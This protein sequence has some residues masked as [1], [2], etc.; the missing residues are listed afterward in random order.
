MTGPEAERLISMYLFNRTV[1]RPEQVAQLSQWLTADQTH[2]DQYLDSVRFHLLLRHYFRSND[3][4]RQAVFAEDSAI[5]DPSELEQELLQLLWMERRSPPIPLERPTSQPQPQEPS[6]CHRVQKPSRFWPSVLVAATAAVVLLAVCI[7]L[8]PARPVA[9]ATL[10][11]TM[12]VQ[13]LGQGAGVVRGYRFMNNGQPFRLAS[14]LVRLTFDNNAEFVVQGPTE[15]RICSA[16]R[17]NLS[18]GTLWATVPPLAKGFRVDLPGYGIV[19]LGTEFGLQADVDGTS[20]LLMHKGKVALIWQAEGLQKGQEIIS[21]GLACQIGTGGQIAPTQIEPNRFVRAFNSQT[22][23]VWRGEPLDL[24]DVVGGGNGL[25]RGQAHMGI[26]IYTGLTVPVTFGPARQGPVGYVPAVGNSLIDGVF[27]PGA[28]GSDVQVSSVGHIWRGC[29][30]TSGALVMGPANGGYVGL[31]QDRL[32]LAGVPYGLPGRPA[33]SLHANVGITF[34]LRSIQR[35][36]RQIHEGLTLCRF[37]ALAG[38]ADTAGRPGSGHGARSSMASLWVLI[39][40]QVRWHRE[41][42]MA[43][44]DPVQIDLPLEQDP[45]FLTIAVTEGPDRDLSGDWVILGDPAISLS[46][47]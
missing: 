21:Q 39:D 47:D 5:I 25:G 31:E 2:I 20:R 42:L 9:V 29:P 16:D 1:M 14:G 45:H 3:A 12:A 35:F 10:T 17:I 28:S 44:L 11:D 46:Y 40:G 8:V 24:A 26:H 13:W 7:I 4:A 32:V 37:S 38:L 23:L 43:G 34:D 41:D 30:R 6:Q 27:V 15:F 22:G 18:Y 36:C 19:D 33:I